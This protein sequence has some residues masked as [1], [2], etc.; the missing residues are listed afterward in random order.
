MN[1]HIQLCTS[2][3]NNNNNNKIQQKNNWLQ[4]KIIFG[5]EKKKTKEKKERK[6]PHLRW[7]HK[8]SELSVSPDDKDNSS[9]KEDSN[10]SK[11]NKI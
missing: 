11:C 4:F 3:E 5:E 6:K 2:I 10:A 9:D 7:F 8:V 1:L